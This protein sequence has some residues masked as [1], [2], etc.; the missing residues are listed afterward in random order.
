MYLILMTEIPVL[1][2]VIVLLFNS[3]GDQKEGLLVGILVAT[4]MLSLFFLLM[5]L[6]LMT[7]IDHRGVHYKYPPLIRKWRLIPKAQINSLQLVKVNPLTDF[8]GWGIKGNRTT[9]AY[10]VLGDDGLLLDIGEEKE[11]FI[12]TQKKNELTECIKNW[13][14]D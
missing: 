10:S 5:N 13:M 6:K 12:G 9:K 7:R 4:L 11:I 8:G 14:E 3:S 2:L 1:I